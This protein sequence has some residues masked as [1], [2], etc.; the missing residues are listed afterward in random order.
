MVELGVMKKMPNKCVTKECTFIKKKNNTAQDNSKKEK[1]SIIKKA[2]KP[3]EKVE[4]K[5]NKGIL[6]NITSWLKDNNKKDEEK[7]YK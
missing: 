6:T 7:K 3:V 5:E 1:T 2:Q 4:T